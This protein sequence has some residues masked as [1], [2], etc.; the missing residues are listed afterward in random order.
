MAYAVR[1]RSARVL[2]PSIWRGPRKEKRLA[3]TFDDGPSE[4]TGELLELLERAG[5]RC[6]F[7]QIGRHVER[8]SEITAEVTR[9]GHEIGNHTYSHS[10]LYL[11]HR[12]FIEDEVALCQDAIERA[13]GFR[14]VLFRAPYGCRWLGLRQAQQRHGLMGVMWTAIGR[15]WNQDAQHVYRRMKRSAVPGAILCLHDGRELKPK[16]DIRNT[17][18]AVRR[19]LPELREQGYHLVTVSELLCQKPHSTVSSA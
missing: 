9:R 19:L 8:L 15:D 2:A 12:Q 1:G 17:I 3:L 7:F 10:P 13:S 11:R 4:S 14:P 6:T 16:P 18:E 5:A